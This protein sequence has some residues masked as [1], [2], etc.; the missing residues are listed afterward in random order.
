MNRMKSIDELNFKVPNGDCK[1]NGIYIEDLEYELNF[2]DSNVQVPAD[3]NNSL[4]NIRRKQCC[5]DGAINS[6]KYTMFIGDNGDSMTLF[7]PLEHNSI[8]I[9]Q[10]RERW[11]TDSTTSFAQDEWKGNL[12]LVY[13]KRNSVINHLIISDA[14][15]ATY[16][17]LITRNNKIEVTLNQIEGHNVVYLKWTFKKSSSYQLS[18][19]ISKNREIAKKLVDQIAEIE[20]ITDNSFK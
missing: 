6:Q 1:R 16:R 20:G 15:N 17:Q 18:E 14:A 2:S 4:A 13:G 7:N 19:V 3:N 5:K 8:L 12:M 10:N 11:D 9:R